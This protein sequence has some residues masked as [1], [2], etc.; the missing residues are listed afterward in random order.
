MTAPWQQDYDRV[1]PH[2][3]LAA[4]ILENE[5]GFPPYSVVRAT[6]E[7]DQQMVADLVLPNGEFVAVRTRD[8]YYFSRYPNDVTFRSARASGAETEVSKLLRGL[9][10]WWFYAFKAEEGIAFLQWTLIDLTGVRSV[11]NHCVDIANIDG[12]T[13]FRVVNLH[14]IPEQHWYRCS[15]ARI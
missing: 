4:R 3:D 12:E 11:L 5:M 14:Q 8:E 9:G 6:P 2:T 13:S 7:Q 15:S 10:C 1:D